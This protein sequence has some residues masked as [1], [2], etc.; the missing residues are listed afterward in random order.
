MVVVTP[1]VVIHNE[2]VRMNSYT[3]FGKDIIQ[4]LYYLNGMPFYYPTLT[5]VLM[6]RFVL[7]QAGVYGPAV[8]QMELFE[9]IDYGF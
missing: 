4:N 3:L 2:V 9:G 8:I 1:G 5:F 6:L 7:S